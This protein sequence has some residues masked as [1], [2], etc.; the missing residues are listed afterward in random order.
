MDAVQYLHGNQVVHKDLKLENWVYA[1]A[2]E[3]ARLKLIDFGFSE[4][5]SH[6][7]PMTAVMGTIFYVA[8]EVLERYYDSKCDVWS[9]GVIAFML[10]CGLPPF[11]GFEDSDEDIMIKI[12]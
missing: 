2:S 5:F 4:V 1:D 3:N 9:L 8:P 6:D 11:G 12:L 7:A 10:L